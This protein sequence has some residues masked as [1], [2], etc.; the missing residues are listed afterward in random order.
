SAS[1]VFR[2]AD[3]VVERVCELSPIT[4]TFVGVAG[5]ET[6]LD[7]FSPAAGER[8]LRM[9][10]EALAEVAALSPTDPDDVLARAVMSERLEV[11]RELDRRGEVA[12]TFGVIESPGQS[13]RQVF[14]VMPSSSPDDALAIVERLRA[15]PASL[16]SWRETLEDLI[17]DESTL[18]RRHVVGVADQLRAMA[19]GGFDDLAVRLARS[20]GVD[21]ESSGLRDATEV[22]TR[23]FGEMSQWL[24]TSCAPHCAGSPYVGAE[25]Y[26]LWS[27]HY[28]GV[29][30]DPLETY[31]WGW[32][33]LARLN[34]RMWHLAQDLAPGV[35][36]LAEVARRLD[37][38][39]RLV[40]H[41]TEE[42]LDRLRTFTDGVVARLNGREFSIDERIQHCDV[43]LAPQGSAAAPYYMMPSEDLS[44][45][46]TTWYPTLGHDEFPWWPLPSTWCHEAV[47]GHH[48]QLATVVINSHRLSR[49]QRL[50]G[51]TSGWAEGW[52]L[53][54]ER[55]MEELG[56]FEDPAVEMGFLQGQAL[57]AARV[58]VDIG[59]HL[60]FRAPED[61]GALEGLGDVSGRVWTPE[62]AVET[63]VQRAVESRDMSLSEVDRYLA[64]PAQ[65]ISYKVGEREWLSARD[66]E[67]TRLGAAFSL[68]DFHDRAL[69]LGP[70]ALTDL[71]ALLGA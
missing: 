27:R 5:H 42:L 11:G 16:S 18:A 44:R 52:A 45:P 39:P 30:V 33:E 17:R 41:G 65:A 24:T 25:R 67:R 60:Q 66:A 59:M 12:R 13:I 1:E 70:V 31:Q 21:A 3:R 63:L 50:L 58:V 29:E 68:R 6:E 26:S 48:L 51:Y 32:A 23:A 69:A 37:R 19:E 57:R 46:G 47:P 10:E 9:H 43:R 64:I 34:E 55:L 49:F 2:V 71:R 61:F 53:Y 20:C 35:A 40:V 36:N 15:V 38:D 8:R 22:A 56:Y 62:M 7:D 54:A 4:A 14:E 28:L